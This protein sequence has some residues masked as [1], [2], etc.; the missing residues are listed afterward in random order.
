[1][2]GVIGIE[3]DHR[4]EFGPGAVDVGD[5]VKDYGDGGTQACAY[6]GR[7]AARQ[8]VA[9]AMK[10]LDDQGVNYELPWGQLQYRLVGTRQIPVHGGVGSDIYNAMRGG[11]AQPGGL[12]PSFYGSSI[13]MTVSY[14]TGAPQAEGFLTYSQS[15]NPASPHYADQTERFSNKDWI[16]LPFTEAAIKADAGYSTVSLSE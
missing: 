6:T 14:E 3:L 9:R 10:A 15:T 8:A 12:P 11:I 16:R 7:E 2:A 1:M 5:A 13:V 4:V